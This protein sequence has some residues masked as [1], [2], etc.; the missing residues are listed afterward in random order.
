[1]PNNKKLANYTGNS[2]LPTRASSPGSWVAASEIYQQSLAQLWP[3]T[4]QGAWVDPGFL[5]YALSSGVVSAISGTSYAIC[6]GSPHIRLE[7]SDLFNVIGTRYGPGDGVSTFNTPFMTPVYGYSKCTTGSGVQAPSGVG[8]LPQHTHTLR[9]GKNNNNPQASNGSGGAIATPSFTFVSSSDGSGDNHGRHVEIIPLIAS[10][11]ES[12]PV[13]TVIM[14]LTPNSAT[15]A[16]VFGPPN[17]VIAS[18]QELSRQDYPTLYERIG[19]L[20]G[21]GDGSTTFNLPDLRGVFLRAPVGRNTLQPS[22]YKDGAY[23]DDGFISHDH[24]VIAQRVLGGSNRC[25]YTAAGTAAVTPQSDLS[26]IGSA[27]ENRP[28]NI[29]L[30][31]HVVIQE[32]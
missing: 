26:S 22:G 27:G 21:S 29:T 16:E 12:A 17:A 31:Y 18:G 11:S 32:P 9:A 6:D 24:R 20:Y 5:I 13:G 8:V 14:N 10:T 25:D 4:P 1:M 15:N 2:T 19:N 30:A 28:P 3:S 23:G 7:F